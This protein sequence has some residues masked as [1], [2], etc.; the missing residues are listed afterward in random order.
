MASGDIHRVVLV[1]DDLDTGEQY[2][3]G[4]HFAEEV[5]PFTFADIGDDVKAAWDSAG[6]GAAL[7]AL[8][9]SSIR[10]AEITRRRIRPLEAS[11]ESYTTGLPIVGTAATGSGPT[12][13][14]LLASIR[15]ALI[16]RRNRGRMFWPTPAEGLVA[17]GGAIT[18][19]LALDVA[20]QMAGMFTALGNDNVTPVVYSAVQNAATPGYAPPAITRVLVDRRT[21]TQR[22]RAELGA[23][24]ESF[25]V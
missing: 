10:L 2:T 22:R 5:L 16:G 23:I 12:Q 4:F 13:T 24:Y 11:I 17:P 18:A 6:G 3:T 14:S 15:T 25:S 1:F 20:D 21:R 9:G 7:K 19:A 8:Y